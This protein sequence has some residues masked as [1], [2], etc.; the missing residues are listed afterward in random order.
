MS[1]NSQFLVILL[2]K[3]LTLKLYNSNFRQFSPESSKYMPNG[4]KWAQNLQRSLTGQKVGK[5]HL[6]AL[7]KI[8]A[9]RKKMKIVS[10][11]SFEHSVPASVNK[12]RVPPM[13]L[14]VQLLLKHN[15]WEQPQSSEMRDGGAL[16]FSAWQCAQ[17]TVFCCS[18]PKWPKIR[19]LGEGKI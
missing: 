12:C 16:F 11:I 9:S 14:S 18:V 10:K 2:L 8:G 15:C 7:T 19:L 3:V 6:H 5:M 4:Q 1:E 17:Y 13:P